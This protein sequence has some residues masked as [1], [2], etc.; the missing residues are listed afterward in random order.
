MHDSRGAALKV[1][2]RVLIEAEIVNLS[3]G[4][5]ENYCCVD[6]QVVTPDQVGREKVMA[7]PKVSAMSTKMLTK[8]GA[9]ACLLLLAA[10]S[11]S[12]G[13]VASPD[14]LSWT[15]KPDPLPQAATLVTIPPGYH[16][17]TT[18]DGRTIV[19]ADTNFGDPVAHAGID[20]PWPKTGFP[21]QTVALD[22]FSV[23]GPC[24][25]GVCPPQAR[26]RTA[27]ASVEIFGYH[28]STTVALNA[29]RPVR[30]VFG[31]LRA[32]RPH[33]FAAGRRGGC[34]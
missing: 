30:G 3:T 13:W 9:V 14:G 5:D 23:A 22:P 24:P 33:V 32:H 16:S 21:G 4:G 7:P 18:L 15:W 20:R 12:A 19:H 27:T 25:G 11:A 1:G 31:W 8:V 6:I 17:H 28:A 26:G 34:P 29:P 10:S 2:D